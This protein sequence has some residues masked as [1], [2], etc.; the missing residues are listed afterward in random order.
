MESGGY[1]KTHAE[2]VFAEASLRK[3]I[4]FLGVGFRSGNQTTRRFHG[5]TMGTGAGLGGGGW[6]GVVLI[7]VATSLV[8]HHMPCSVRANVLEP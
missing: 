4:I 8:R 6:V 3:S 2:K 5:L 1:R 7:P